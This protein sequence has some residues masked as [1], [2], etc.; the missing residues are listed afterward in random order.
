LKK[1]KKK[2]LNEIFQK[3]IYEYWEKQDLE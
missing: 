2:T 3:M 1:Q